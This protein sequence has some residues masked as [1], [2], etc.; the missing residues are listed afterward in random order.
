MMPVLQIGPLA[1]Q[2]PGLIILLGI[3]IGLSLAEKYAPSRAVPAEQLYRIVIAA[4]IAG[5]IGARLSYAFQYREAFA[6]DPLGLISPNPGLLDPL[7][8]L[9]CAVLVALILG[10]RKGMSL[11]PTLDALTPLFAVFMLALALSQLASGAGFGMETD[12]PWG[13]EFWG[14]SRHPTQ[15]Y[16]AALAVVGLFIFWPARPFIQSLPSGVTFLAFTAYCAAAR[17]LVEAFRGDSLA[18]P[19]GFRSAQIAAWLVLAG[20]LWMI[21]ARRQST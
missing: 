11:W 16:A 21:H 9:V 7:G 17:L 8:G 5:M 15:I 10:Q 20:C 1:L 12:L 3:W 18:L 2:L 13:I 19:G 6:A 4:L 14:A